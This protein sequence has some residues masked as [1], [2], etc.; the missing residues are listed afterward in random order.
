MRILLLG[1]G[2][3]GK[4]IDKL[5]VD[6]MMNRSQLNI[7]DL[8]TIPLKEYDICIN[9]IAYTNVEG[10][11]EETDEMK[12]VNHVFPMLLASQSKCK[13]I[14]F[15]SDYVFDGM[16]R[17]KYTEDDKTGP[18]N[19]YGKYKLLGEQK[20]LQNK[21][22]LVIRTSWLF[23]KTGFPTTI[24]QRL[25]N[26]I[27]VNVVSTQVGTPTY[28]PYLAVEVMN[29]LDR[30]GILH[31][32]GSEELSWYELAKLIGKKINRESLVHSLDSISQK[33]ERPKYSSLGSNKYFRTMP[34]L[35]S[36]FTDLFEF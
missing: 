16:K 32:A 6:L 33:A 5:G 9:C 11:E 36:A 13:I 24:F 17:T 14:H 22:N 1:N 25:I 27:P 21:N 4:E 2:L 29:C 8:N 26:G 7:Y 34:D 3:L 10:C 20:V 18:L 31:L 28:A 35:N 12:Y 30:N 23:G 19:A 15:S